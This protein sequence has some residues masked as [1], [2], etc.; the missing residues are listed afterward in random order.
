MPSSNGVYTLPPG[1]LA[2]TGQVIQASQHNPPLEDIAQALTNRLSRDGTAPM[3]GPVKAADGAVGA[4]SLTFNNAQ[5]T[6]FY[7]TAGGNIGVAV[8]GVETVEFGP[9]GI[10]TGARFLGELISYTGITAPALTVFPYGQTLSRTTYAALWAFAQTQITAGNTFYNN[11][12]GSTTFG[13][14]DLRG[15]TLAGKDDMGGSSAFRLTTANFGSN[16]DVLG[17][18]GGSETVTLSLAQ[19]PT[20]ITSNGTIT[21][22]APNSSNFVTGAG[23]EVIS[24]GGGAANKTIV[25]S[26]TVAANSSSA[27]GTASVTSNNTGGGAHNNVQPTM[28]VNYLLFAGA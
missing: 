2:V 20:G 15:R 16:P 27:S 23:T 22:V 3:T 5:S 12:D 8:G 10:V 25:T 21:A 9:G 19:L 24:F 17:N 6:G 11:G 26:N 7:K 1:Y 28:V 4:P 13:I 14:G 18:S